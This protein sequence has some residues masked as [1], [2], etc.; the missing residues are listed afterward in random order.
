[1]RIMVRRL[2]VALALA[3]LLV[4]HATVIPALPSD[5]TDAARGE[6]ERD[7][8]RSQAYVWGFVTEKGGAPVQGVNVTLYNFGS[9]L[10]YTTTSLSSGHY[11]L[12]PAPAQYTLKVT[13]SGY[14]D[15]TTTVYVRPGQELRYDINITKI[16]PVNSKI[17]G[18]VRNIDTSLPV[19]FAG[20]T[21][22]DL[23]NNNTITTLAGLLGNYN[24]D[25]YEG[26]FMIIGWALNYLTKCTGGVVVKPNQTVTL[27]I[28]IYPAPPLDATVHGQVR[29]IAG[30]PLP[31]AGILFYDEAKHYFTNVTTGPNGLYSIDLYKGN[32]VLVADDPNSTQ[33]DNPII[34]VSTMGGDV[35]QD[36]RLRSLPVSRILSIVDATGLGYGR[37]TINLTTWG[38]G[39]VLGG[40]SATLLRFVID[41]YNGNGD[42]YTS[43]SEYE[44][45]HDYFQTLLRNSLQLY[46]TKQLFRLDGRDYQFERDFLSLDIDLEGSAFSN[47]PLCIGLSINSSSN[48][49]IDVKSPRHEVWLNKTYSTANETNLLSIDFPGFFTIRNQSAP[50][51]FVLNITGDLSIGIDPPLDPA[52]DDNIVSVP[53]TFTL[54]DRL[55]PMADAGFNRTLNQFSLVELN[56]TASSD[57]LGIS[58]YTWDLGDGTKQTVTM[59]IITHSYSE[60]GNYTVNLTVTDTGGLNST[61]SIWVRVLDITPPGVRIMFNGSSVNEDTPVELKANA[62][63]NAGIDTVTWKVNGVEYG[64]GTSLLHTFAQPGVYA[65]DVRVVDVS[66]L[67]AFDELNLTVNDVTDPVADMGP[68]IIRDED[69]EIVF[70][71]SLSTDNVGITSYKWNFGDSVD[72]FDG[73]EIPHVFKEPGIYNVTL[74]VTDTAGNWNSSRIQVTVRDGT[75]PVAEILV[76]RTAIQKGDA[77]SFDGTRST[78]NVGIAQYRWNFDDGTQ[79]TGDKVEHKFRKAGKFNVSLVVTDAQGHSDSRSV[80]INVREPQTA[81][82][83]TMALAAIVIVVFIAGIVSVYAYRRLKYGGYRVDEVFI[84]CHDG[85][86]IK[87][88]SARPEQ[89]VDKDILASMLTAVQDF[90]RDSF[91]NRQEN[92][93]KLEFGKKT[94]ILIES[95]KLIYLA[96]VVAGHDPERL[97]DD[98]KRAISKVEK[99]YSPRLVDWDGAVGTFSDIDRLVLPLL[100]K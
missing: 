51:G 92:L 35:T 98:I 7:A 91:Q 44:Y 66:G 86:L 55:P 100:T 48:G 37:L 22:Y 87:H 38:K 58:S 79:A 36:F 28:D 43:P 83:N 71:A 81:Q 10:Y 5:G 42:L 85:R 11:S 53:I 64:N 99:E 30:N 39:L 3:A 25:V 50:Q 69:H 89:T 26:T 21:L 72:S 1:M 68:P 16:P 13:K 40:L 12:S 75:A 17:S 61:D 60:Y 29:D 19:G 6:C 49:T 77:V 57:N 67:A 76:N 59:P 33:A 4:A 15:F 84:I 96:V 41:I 94:K 24:M 46:D 80:L 56:A 18:T 63:D 74:N 52:P 62:T 14:F 32:F 78:D 54:A 82:V 31:G 20:I 73:R 93:G 47:A 9:W 2:P 97:R 90:V 95:G 8:G 34:N 70:N 45:W 23:M 65:I 27:N 88:V